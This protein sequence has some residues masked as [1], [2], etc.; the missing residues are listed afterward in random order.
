MKA[1]ETLN[2]MLDK[3]S[4]K[5]SREYQGE[6]KIIC[7]DDELFNCTMRAF[8]WYENGELLNPDTSHK[9]RDEVEA[10]ENKE[11]SRK[12][13]VAYTFK[14]VRS[15]G[16]ES[17]REL[18]SKIT[19][20]LSEKGEYLPARTR[21]KVFLGGNKPKSKKVSTLK[22]WTDRKKA[23][24]GVVRWLSRRTEKQLW[25]G[26]DVNAEEWKDF[27]NRV[28]FTS[29]HM[30]ELIRRASKGYLAKF[31]KVSDKPRRQQVPPSDAFLSEMQRILSNQPRVDP[32]LAPVLSWYQQNGDLS[33]YARERTMADTGVPSIEGWLSDD[34]VA[35]QPAEMSFV[36]GI[37]DLR[38]VD[39]FLED[40]EIV[41]RNPT[42]PPYI[43]VLSAIDG[44]TL[45]APSYWMVIAH[46]N[47]SEE[48][49][50]LLQHY[51][52]TWVVA[53]SRY[54]PAAGEKFFFSN[55]A[56][57][58][59]NGVVIFKLAKEGRPPL[60]SKKQVAMDETSRKFGEVREYGVYEHELRMEIYLN[61][62]SQLSA[63][64]ADSNGARDVLC[65]TVGRKAMIAAV[66]C[67]YTHMLFSFPYRRCSNFTV[68]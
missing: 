21:P 62:L 47:K 50:E 14:C 64:Q 13:T 41:L 53:E 33:E 49:M 4:G 10:F 42:A 22:E 46:S 68:F 25:D 26:E 19:S 18:I 54:V 40:E 15:L 60:L 34:W 67:S 63:I 37:M 2:S 30:D 29:A 3:N 28:G 1:V 55:S 56:L 8:K 52:P 35:V 20:G 51:F 48:V 7:A 39:S 17:L 24:N 59:G 31:M 58:I 43:S 16:R 6:F 36:G 44:N 9:W 66:V 5:S 57:K 45:T 61:Y 32:A 23:K 12:Y 38:V 65:I 11:W 27:K